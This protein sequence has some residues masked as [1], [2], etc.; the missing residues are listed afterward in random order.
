VIEG[1]YDIF[2][3]P[4]GAKGKPS[5]C[6]LEP[7]EPSYKNGKEVACPSGCQFGYATT[8]KMCAH[9][10]INGMT[11]MSVCF[12]FLH[13]LNFLTWWYFLLS[14]LAEVMYDCSGGSQ[15]FGPLVQFPGFL[16]PI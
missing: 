12:I 1:W 13:L 5:H 2:F 4:E 7:V 16:F 6:R 15:L 3:C 11:L 10:I 8:R 9:D 14:I